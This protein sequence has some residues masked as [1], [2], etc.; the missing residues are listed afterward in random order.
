MGYHIGLTNESTYLIWHLDKKLI[1]RVV[2]AQVEEGAGLDNNHKEPDIRQRVVFPDYDEDEMASV[3]ESSEFDEHFVNNEDINDEDIDDK[4]I[5]NEV[6]DDEAVD[7]K[8]VN[9][10]VIDDK[11]IK[12]VINERFNDDSEHEQL[13]DEVAIDERAET[14]LP[15]NNNDLEDNEESPTISL[16]QPA[17]T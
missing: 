4:D 6:V 7:D 13:E 3:S 9:D 10:E 15:I 14:R 16:P 1:Q 17:K 5:D 2:F 8:V 12:E 11:V